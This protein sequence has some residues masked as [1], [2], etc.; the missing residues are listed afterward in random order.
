MTAPSYQVPS[1]LHAVLK[2]SFRYG[3]SLLNGRPKEQKGNAYLLGYPLKHSLAPTLH[4]TLF[5]LRQIPWRYHALES[6]DKQD[7]VNLLSQPGCVGAAVTMPHKVSFIPLVDDLTEEA[8]GIGAINTVFIRLD[9][10]G[11]RK[12]IG[13]NTDTVGIRESFLRNST[14]EQLK[15][16]KSSPGLVIGAGGAC[17][18]AIY[19]LH[20]WLHVDEIY[21]VNRL[22]S[23]VEDII[24][25]FSRVSSF[26]AKL[27]FVGSPNEAKSLPAPFF[28]VGTVP[29]FPPQTDGEKSARQCIEALMT[30]ADGNQGVV[31]EMCYHPSIQTSFA[32]FAENAGWKVIPGTEPMIWQGIAQQVLWTENGKLVNESEYQKIE[33]VIEAGLA[34]HC[35]TGTG[36]KSS[37]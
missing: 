25:S 32:V 3:S 14:P 2:D 17:R 18:S 15:R 16:G 29:D 28:V 7:L 26:K 1:D 34:A 4:N 36:R 8:K 19:A 24:S 33:K 11:K 9:S 6:K 22:Q 31:L 23:E 13:T 27:R 5:D 35:P 12:Y 20:H 30:R 21:I 10:S 37:L